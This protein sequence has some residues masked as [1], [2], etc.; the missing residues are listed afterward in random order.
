MSRLIS[1]RLVGLFAVVLLAAGVASG[2]DWEDESFI[3]QDPVVQ[4]VTR[5][6][7]GPDDALYVL[8][9][10]W[11]DWEDTKITLMMSPDKGETWNG[12]WIAFDGMPYD[13]AAICANEQGLHLLFTEY[14]EDEEEEYKWLYCANSTDGGET[15]AEPV[16]VGERDNIE[17][18]DA[19]TYGDVLF[20]YAQ[21]MDWEFE[22]IYSYLYVSR[23]GGGTWEEKPLLPWDTV[24]HP[25]FAVVD[26]VIHMA[27]G[28]YE[29]A[30]RIRYCR[31]T[32]DGDTWTT[33]VAVS[34]GAGPHAQLAQIAVADEA[35]VVAWED[36]R[37]NYFNIV[38]SRSTD[39]GATWS[40]DLQ[41]NDTF[42]GARP[43]LLTDEEGLHAVWC[44]Y[45]GDSGW[46][47]S[48]S[49]ADY[50]IIRYK[51]SDDSGLTWGDE[52]RVSQNEHIDPMDLPQQGAS[53]VRLGEYD[54][55][56]CAVWQDKRD[57]NIDLYMRN[58]LGPPALGD[59]NCDGIVN[60]FDIRA[61][62]L[63]LTDE[64]GYAD[65]YP[66]CDRDLADVNGDGAV[67]NF[68]ISP[69]VDLLTGG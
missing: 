41:L 18:V 47:A 9:L 63:A 20:V 53:Y 19:F 5:V 2:G 49:S 65:A 68:D 40:S 11:T 34:Q 27:F 61:F 62:V 22:I 35:L 56:F 37:S 24:E 38:Y 15:F 51:F 50:G 31:S 17:A 55:G 69:F 36:D 1:A 39:D 59:L 23:D 7:T 16:R 21:N 12:P 3:T 60:N 42:Y 6:A 14:F 26:G 57:G 48:W 52:F 25:T 33:P 54:T 4:Y 29:F 28:R 10:D 66:D 64:A 43:K 58:N 44:Q 8:W 46:P 13:N 30:P 67:N 45:H 32:D